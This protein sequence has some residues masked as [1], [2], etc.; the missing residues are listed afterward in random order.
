MRLSKL[1]LSRRV[2]DTLFRNGVRTVEQ[3]RDMTEYEIEHLRGVG[4]KT[5]R[6][7]L[8]ARDRLENGSREE[9]Q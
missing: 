1:Y 9:R 8:S 5:C 6:E 2:N 4:D 3:L 7:I